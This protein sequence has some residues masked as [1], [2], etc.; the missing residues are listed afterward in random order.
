M[1]NDLKDL[2]RANVSA[3]PP[4]V[5]DV[6]AVV[7]AGRRRV[8]AR[9]RVRLSVAA[10]ATAAVV[11]GAALGWPG[12]DGLG[13]EAAAPPAPEAPTITL[14]DAGRA[15]EG[16]DYDVLTS[17][18]NDDLD[19]DNGQYLDGV[20]DDGLVLFRDGPRRGLDEARLALLD[21]ATGE[22]DW[23][24]DSGIGSAQAQPV[25]LTRD[26]LVLLAPV[27]DDADEGATLVAHVFDRDDRT[28]TRLTWPGAPEVSPFHGRLGPDGRLYVLAPATQ[29]AVPEGGW[30]TQ[31]G[32]DAEDADAEG[33]TY[34]LWS[35]SLTD[36]TD[37]RDE[38]LRVG[39][40][41]FTDAAMVWTDRT[42]GDPGRVHVRDLA[43]GEEHA[44]DP[45]TGE[46][47]NLLGFGATGDRIVLSQ[48]CGTYGDVRDDRVQVVSTEGEQVVTL[49]DTGAEGWLPP[50][51]DVV[52]VSAH[53]GDDRAGTYVYDLVGDRFLRVSD[54]VSSW[55]LGG[56][57]G[58]PRQVMWHT[59]ENRGRGATQWL[60]VLR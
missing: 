9:R 31:P 19:S 50:G 55:S 22:K 2:L 12:D 21:P 39:D 6:A 54:G 52:A 53:R 56:P 51:S 17:Y 40:V 24:P 11:G 32:G 47:C 28:W 20:T 23:L 38:G 57:T 29:G 5:L 42:N 10:L 7:G 3:P 36:P 46:R 49:Q 16:R 1:V 15:V 30:P 45:R 48:Y 41:A 14:A 4:D 18:T 26:R 8:R 58:D 35:V 59:P 25:A 43:S 34:D 44:F 27:D 33:D 60:G 37:A 13:A